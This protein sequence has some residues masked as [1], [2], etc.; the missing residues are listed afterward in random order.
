MSTGTFICRRE[1]ISFRFHTENPLH[2]YNHYNPYRSAKIV[3]GRLHLSLGKLYLT[4]AL[5]KQLI[6]PAS[7]HATKIWDRIMSNEIDVGY[8]PVGF[9]AGSFRFEIYLSMDDFTHVR[10]MMSMIL[11]NS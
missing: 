3:N 5:E 4:F 1:K 9:E 2:S 11:K 8:N 7:T 6:P 10:L